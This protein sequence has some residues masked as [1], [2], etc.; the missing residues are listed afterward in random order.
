[1]AMVDRGNPNVLSYV[2]TGG[3][4]KVLTV[5][6]F[7]GSASD[8]TLAQLGGGKLGRVIVQNR[9]TVAANGL[10]VAPLGVI[11]AEIN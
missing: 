11:V 3:G 9:A 6:N 5:L 4:K 10:H 7:G 1:M 8:L 2:R